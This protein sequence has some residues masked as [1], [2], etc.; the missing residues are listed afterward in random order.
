M[1]RELSTP[2]TIGQILS[3]LRRNSAEDP[4]KALAGME[5]FLVSTMSKLARSHPNEDGDLA[6][7]I[8]ETILFSF[9][10]HALDVIPDDSVA[11][12]VAAITQ[13]IGSVFPETLTYPTVTLQ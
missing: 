1:T 10:I 5:V 3:V 2:E 13:S 8:F 4:A 9:A 6:V 12:Y 7:N 11:T